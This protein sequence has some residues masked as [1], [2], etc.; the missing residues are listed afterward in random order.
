MWFWLLCGC[1]YN[2]DD[3]GIEK[4][5]RDGD[6]SWND[7]EKTVSENHLFF[8]LKHIDILFSFCHER[9]ISHKHPKKEFRPT[10]LL[11]CVVLSFMP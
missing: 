7:Q 8:T 3:D 11:P 9:H 1:G 10:L 2:G 4:V 5:G 6:I